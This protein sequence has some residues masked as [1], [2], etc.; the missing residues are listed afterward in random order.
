MGHSVTVATLP[1]ARLVAWAF[2]LD[3]LEHTKQNGVFKEG[4]DL[5]CPSSVVDGTG[6]PRPWIVA[7]V[8]NEVRF[9][10]LKSDEKLKG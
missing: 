1:A 6:R 2:H 8:I 5:E 10:G 9:A 3:F 7:T 4:G